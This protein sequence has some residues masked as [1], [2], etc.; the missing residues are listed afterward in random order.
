M[1]N[2]LY[3]SAAFF[4]CL[5]AIGYIIYLKTKLADYKQQLILA[6]AQ[7]Q[8]NNSLGG[9]G[10]ALAAIQHRLGVI[11]RAQQQLDNLSTSFVNLHHM[12]G[13]KQ[14]RG[15]YGEQK[16]ESIIRDELS[17][18]QYAM[19]YSFSTR[20]RPDCVLFLPP[21]HTPLA[22]DSKFP[23]ESFAAIEEATL[24]GEKL[25]AELAHKTFLSD[26]KKHIT[27]VA[28]KYIIPGETQ[29]MAFIFLPAESI[30]AYIAQHCPMLLELASRERVVLT[31]PNSLM[32]TV[33]IVQAL[34]REVNM[35][36][37]ARLIQA[38][39]TT[40]LLDISKLMKQANDVQKRF[41]LFEKDF[42]DI[43]TSCARITKR[44]EKIEELGTE[45]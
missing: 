9:F 11:D 10:Q 13:A 7:L 19:Q 33:K 8:S 38:E 28:R 24:K 25:R 27:D 21:N 41:I 32:L 36:N 42:S 5:A 35:C 18:A 20:V 22:I 3:L 12:L 30:Y 44:G 26:M 6:Q 39:I 14:Q 31:S 4:I 43:A 37:N 2:Y 29:A 1:P 17:A 45:R 15:Y 23:L 16:L 40:L 34:V